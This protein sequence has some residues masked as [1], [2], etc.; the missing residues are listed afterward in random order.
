MTEADTRRSDNPFPADEDPL[1]GY[2]RVWFNL[3]RVQR[4]LVPRIS[5]ILREAGVEDPIWYEIL[6]EI[7]RAGPEGVGMA[8]L[9]SRLYVP[10]YALSRHTRRMELAGLIHRTPKPGRGRSRILTLTPE[11]VGKHERIWPLY[12]A[13]IHEELMPR[14][15]TA[16]AYGLARLLIR[17]YP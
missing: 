8:E 2:N 12:Q 16:E 15:S 7:E 5:R 4:S 1:I 14:L 11:G 3:L 17:L 9:E 13:A 10:Q 6:L